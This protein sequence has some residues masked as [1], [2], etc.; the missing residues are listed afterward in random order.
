MVDATTACPVCSLMYGDLRTGM[1][2]AG[3]Q[4]MLWVGSDDRT[5]WKHKGRH[6]VLGLWRQIKIDLWTRHLKD[7]REHH[8]HEISELESEIPF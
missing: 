7:C 2:F 3:V 6:T 5:L 4:Q 1:D 8:E